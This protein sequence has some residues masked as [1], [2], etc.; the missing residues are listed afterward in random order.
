VPTT[1][2]HAGW[3]DLD[4]TNDLV[5]GTGPVRVAVGRDFGDVTPLRGVIRGGGDH[6]LSVAV[7]TRRVHRGGGP[8]PERELLE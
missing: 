5:P 3:L 6:T 2:G 1:G 7:G 4:P 8:D